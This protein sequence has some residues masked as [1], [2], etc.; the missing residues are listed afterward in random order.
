M[1]I[2][3]IPGNLEDDD[4]LEM[5]NAGLIPAAV[6]DDYLAEFWRKVFPNIIVHDTV[7]LRTGA[8][9][10]VPVR[11]N[12]PKLLAE[13]NAF[14]AKFGLGTAFGN[15]MEKRYLASTSFVKQATAEAERGKFLALIGFLR[16]VQRAVPDRLPAHGG[17][18]IPGV[19]ARPEREEPCWRHRR[20]AAHAGNGQGHEGR[21]HQATS[22]PTS[23]PA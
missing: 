11:K 14:L 1:A 15:M 20:D 9:I 19:A 2:R 5:V 22:R 7:T 12:N 6:V 23:T 21:R 8:N 4:V 3:E 17:A 18:G 13:L 16:E 10:A